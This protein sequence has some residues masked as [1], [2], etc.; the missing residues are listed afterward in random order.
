MEKIRKIKLG[1]RESKLAV[2]QAEIIAEEIKKR[3][4]H[5]EVE[6]VTFKTTGDK[7]LD[8]TLD[9]IGGKGLFVKELDT[10]LING[11]IDIAVHSLKDMPAET[12]ERLPIVAFSKRESPFDVLILPKGQDK[13]DLSKPVGCSSLRRKVQIEKMG[14]YIKIEPVRGNVLTRLEKLDRGEYSALVLAEAGIIRLGLEDRIFK[15]FSLEEIIPAAG[16]GIIAV[17]GRRGEDYS[18]LDGVNDR[19]SELC[20]RAERAFVRKLD[21]GCSSP[22]AGFAFIENENIVLNGLYADKD[23]IL[24]DRIK[25]KPEDCEELGAEL[26]E[27]LKGGRGVTV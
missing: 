6:I 15:R 3:T 19:E 14:P 17:Q 9:K 21:G 5:A 11:D 7:I 26:A 2:I 10:A 22:I 24:N 13:I 27:R 12:D 20:A 18:Y 23:F 4:S 25:G 16:Q 8:R 1:S